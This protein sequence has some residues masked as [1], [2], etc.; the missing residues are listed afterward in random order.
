MFK[1]IFNKLL[2]TKKVNSISLEKALQIKTEL[3]ANL[4]SE[5][6]K[7]LKTELHFNDENEIKTTKVVINNRRL[8]LKDLQSDLKVVT[9]ELL[10]ANYLNG[11]NKYIKDREETVKLLKNTTDF[12]NIHKDNQPAYVLLKQLGLFKDISTYRN[13]VK[14]IDEKLKN[15]NKNTIISVKLKT[16]KFN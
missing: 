16:V 11:V 5:Q 3:V 4:I 10:K 13:Q 2:G 6:E 7:L 1:R 14:E 9:A 8:R 15:I 12:T